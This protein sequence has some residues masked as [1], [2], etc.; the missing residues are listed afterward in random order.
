M[1]SEHLET[2]VPRVAELSKHTGLVNGGDSSVKAKPN[3]AVDYRSATAL[4]LPA[5]STSVLP[6]SVTTGEMVSSWGEGHNEEAS[7]QLVTLFLTVYYP[8]K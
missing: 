8:L 6:D 7:L 4:A 1:S 2:A 3:S 5:P